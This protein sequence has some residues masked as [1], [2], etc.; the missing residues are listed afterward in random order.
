MAHV[1][2]V[3]ALQG[4]LSSAFENLPEGHFWHRELALAEP[5]INPKPVGHS[6]SKWS[7]HGALSACVANVPSPQAEQNPSKNKV[8]RV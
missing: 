5:R 3:N 8:A 2:S 7:E 1:A 4:F 6:L